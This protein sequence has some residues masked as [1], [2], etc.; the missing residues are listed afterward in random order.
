[1]G[2][3]SQDSFHSF[4]MAESFSPKKVDLILW[5]FSM[6]DGYLEFNNS[7]FEREIRNICIFWLRKVADFYDEN[8]PGVI[9]IYYWDSPFTVVKWNDINTIKSN[10]FRSH[11][12]LSANFDFVIGHIHVGEFLDSLNLSEQRNKEL[13]L[14]DTHHPNKFGHSI[15][16]ELLYKLLTSE[17]VSKLKTIP[18]NPKIEWVCIGKAARHTVIA[19]LLLERRRQTKASFIADVPKIN[20]N[21]SAGSLIAMLKK[22]DFINHSY[23]WE[24][25]LTE[26]ADPIRSDRNIARLLPLCENE[27]RLVFDLWRFRPIHAIHFFVMNLKDAVVNISHSKQIANRRLGFFSQIQFTLGASN[28]S[29]LRVWIDGKSY[30][31]C[32]NLFKLYLGATQSI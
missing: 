10:T 4:L 28:I 31:K 18:N 1:M 7:I 24:D 2:H 29:N 27:E 5:E 23:I 11:Q 30:T 8:P 16:A 3:G 26:R 32:T 9:F 13:F 19:D 6:N 14:A 22:Q 25:Y 17:T 21:S 12:H 20:P 15:T